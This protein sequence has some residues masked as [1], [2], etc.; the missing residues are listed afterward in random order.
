MKV[1]EKLPR[2]NI[3]TPIAPSYLY[4]LFLY[5]PNHQFLVS[6]GDNKL[7]YLGKDTKRQ[8]RPI[9]NKCQKIF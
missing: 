8:K 5:T 3:S 9:Y 1:E 4:L 7:A 2:L 6:I